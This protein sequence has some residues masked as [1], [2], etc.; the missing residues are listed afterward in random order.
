MKLAIIIGHEL[1]SKGAKGVY[2]ISGYEYDFNSEIAQ[3]IFHSAMDRALPIRIFKRDGL[4]ISGV[5]KQVQDWAGGN[6]EAVA[7]ELHCNAF[8]G[9]VRG[10]ETLFDK[11]PDDS[12]EFAREIH[13]SICTALNRKNKEDRGIKL[14]EKGDRG[15]INLNLCKI[16]SAIV[17]PFFIDNPEDAALGYSLKKQYAAAIVD[18]CLKFFKQREV[19]QKLN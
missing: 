7:I 16:P 5:Y 10:T 17:E 6:S 18:G 9:K 11:D 3:L 2:P 13:Q 8:N 15:Y 12:I 4:G 1:K 14:I 19:Y